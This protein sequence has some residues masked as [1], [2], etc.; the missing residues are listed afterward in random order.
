MKKLVPF[1]VQVCILF[2][3][4]TNTLTP[5]IV[6]TISASAQSATTITATGNIISDYGLSILSYGLCL[7]QDSLPTTSDTKKEHF[8]GTYIMGTEFN[9][10]FTGLAMNET[11]YVRA[12]AINSDGVAYGK[13]ICVKTTFGPLVTNSVV[14]EITLTEATLTATINPLNTTSENWF[15]YWFDGGSVQKAMVGN[16]SGNTPVSVS[17]KLKGLTPGKTYSFKA[18]SKNEYGTTESATFKFEMYGVS[19]Y[20]GNLYHSVTIG[21]QTWLK[22][23]LKTTHY[24]NGDAIPHVNDPEAWQFLK[25]GA[26][27]RYNN[28][29][30]LSDIYGLLY[31]WYV[32]SDTR[33]L[34]TGWHVPVSDVDWLNL[35]FF[36]AGGNL[37]YPYA[38]AGA[39]MVGLSSGLWK[40]P[41]ILPGVTSYINSSGFTALP[42]GAFYE[43]G[44]IHKYVFMGLNSTAIFW[45][46]DL[47]MG[48]GCPLIIGSDCF[49]DLGGLYNKESGFG[50]RLV[51][52][53]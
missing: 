28:D 11:Y 50:L 32:A 36:L 37:E 34:I 52:N 43:D 44:I 19:D 42:N 46:S 51:K 35:E 9:D 41:V 5:P 27:I 10:S 16:S 26:Y 3:S 48:F 15:E 20:D 53:N 40:N 4:C 1:I 45:S 38:V 47:F 18:K 33:E 29:S 2:S 23:N 24:A 22:E 12:Y 39:K 49:F 25:T 30:K 7:S 31:N 8:P 17:V 6:R 21:K 14:S 13:S